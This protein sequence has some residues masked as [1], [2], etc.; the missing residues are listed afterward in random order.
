MTG[1]MRLHGRVLT[2]GRRREGT[3]FQQRSSQGR[4]AVC[5]QALAVAHRHSHGHRV[6]E[7]DPSLLLAFGSGSPVLRGVRAPG[8]PCVP[9][10]A[11]P[12]SHGRQGPLQCVPLPWA[13]CPAATGQSA[14]NLSLSSTTASIAPFAVKFTGAAPAERTVFPEAPRIWPSL[15]FRQ[16][17]GFRKG[18]SLRSTRSPWGCG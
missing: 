10:P 3:P 14:P 4:W 16:V 18:G 13:W 7:T 15:Q 6:A 2:G 5:P 12:S 9:G 8:H 1:R 11:Q 17:H